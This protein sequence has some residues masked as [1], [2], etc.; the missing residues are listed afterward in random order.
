MF[1][2]S[3]KWL[4]WT[5]FFYLRCFPNVRKNSRRTGC[6]IKVSQAVLS[7]RKIKILLSLERLRFELK[8]ISDGVKDELIEKTSL[9]VRLL[10]ILR[11]WNIRSK[12][13]SGSRFGFLFL[14]TNILTYH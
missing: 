1:L 9:Y 13:D 8:I 4:S 12:S 5:R 6:P 2:S 11:F 7:E 10:Y 14:K 3:V